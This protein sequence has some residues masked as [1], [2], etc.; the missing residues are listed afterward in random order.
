M[1][2]AKADGVGFFPLL[3]VCA[4]DAEFVPCTILP[5]PKKLKETKE[6]YEKV[7]NHLIEEGYATDVESADSIISGMS[8]QWFEQIH[9]G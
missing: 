9:E 1:L 8:E 2:C 4:N 3:P 5:S 6:I 7:V